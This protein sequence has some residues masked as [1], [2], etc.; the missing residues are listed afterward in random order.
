[1]T[2]QSHAEWLAA[3]ETEQADPRYAR[4]DLGS[5][6]E[7]AALMNQADESVPLAVRAALPQ[8]V[9]AIEAVTER[10]RAG[11][12]LLYVGAG[13]AGRMGVVDA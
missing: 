2:G 12:R 10:M 6:G 4:I 13:T 3:L 8:I 11:G 9:P 5:V 1:M 7:L